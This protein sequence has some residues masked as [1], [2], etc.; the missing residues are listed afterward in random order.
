MLFDGDPMPRRQPAVVAWALAILF[1]TYISATGMAS[2]GLAWALLAM[3]TLALSMKPKYLD[4]YVK[5]FGLIVGLYAVML[6]VELV[7]GFQTPNPE[8]QYRFFALTG[9]WGYL[10]ASAWPMIDP[11]N[12]A[13]VINCALIPCFWKALKP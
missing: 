2:Q 9:A 3:P 7:T 4:S 6:I 10:K 1:C 8:T 12:A 13:L 11:N 5:A